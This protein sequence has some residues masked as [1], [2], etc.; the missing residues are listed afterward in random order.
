MIYS[1]NELNS[2]ASLSVFVVLWSK[3]KATLDSGEYEALT[4]RKEPMIQKSSVT[5]HQL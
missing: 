2:L 3:A 5:R 4:S 1:T